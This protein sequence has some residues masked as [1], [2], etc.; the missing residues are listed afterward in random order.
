MFVLDDFTLFFQWLFLVITAIA[1]LISMRFNERESINRGEYYALLLFA[2]SGMLLMAGSGDLILTFLGIEI[3]SIATYV[4]AGFKRD[5][6]AIQRVVLEIFPAGIICYCV[7]A[8]RNRSYLRRHRQHELSFD[9]GRHAAARLSA[10]DHPDRNGSPAGGFRVQGGHRS[11]PCL[12]SRRI[13]RRADS[14]DGLHDGRSQGR[15]FCGAAQSPG[16]SSSLPGSRTGVLCFGF[17]RY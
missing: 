4:L 7:S 17:R 1:A 16:R 2:C 13:R 15:R 8:L 6:V 10:G 12:G 14:G 5:D 3:L 11:V 9:S